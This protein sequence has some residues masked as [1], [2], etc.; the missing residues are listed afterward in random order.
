MVTN[1]MIF[2]P[3]NNSTMKVGCGGSEIKEES[4]FVGFNKFLVLLGFFFFGLKKFEARDS[5]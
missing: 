5:G 4:V 2:F 1:K 3:Q